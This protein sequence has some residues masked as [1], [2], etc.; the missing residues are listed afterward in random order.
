MTCLL[1]NHWLF[2]SSHMLLLNGVSAPATSAPI[3]R[4][5][6]LAVVAAPECRAAAAL[7]VC[8][9]AHMAVQAPV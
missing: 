4:V 8:V 3:V 2:L 5:G 6:G 9:R 1:E 7:A